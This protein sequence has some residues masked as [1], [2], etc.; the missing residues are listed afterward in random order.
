MS[1][2]TIPSKIMAKKSTTEES[3]NFLSN[4][5]RAFESFHRQSFPFRNSIIRYISKNPASPK[6]YQ[7]LIKSCKYFFVENPVLLTTKLRYNFKWKAEFNGIRKE[8][9]IDNLPCKLWITSDIFVLAFSEK[10]VVSSIVSKIYRCDSESLTLQRQTISSDELLILSSNVLALCLVEVIVTNRNGSILVF[11]KLFNAHTKVMAFQFTFP[12]STSTIN[13]KTVKELIKIPHFK[14]LNKFS[15]WKVPDIFDIEG[16]YAYTKKNKHTRFRLYFADT[17][18]E[19]YKKRL[20][21]VIDEI[22]EAKDPNYRPFS[23]HFNGINSEKE[24]QLR[25]MSVKI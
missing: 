15:F 7:K 3:K 1:C 19:G 8:V 4:R 13:A 18:S 11:E 21:T 10:T 23:I 12:S 22:L 17:I 14:N 6:I 25:N 16:F 5:N 2:T 9:K 24:A 20:N